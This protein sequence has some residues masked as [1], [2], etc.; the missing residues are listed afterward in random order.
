[1][2]KPT[3]GLLRLNKPL[4]LTDTASGGH[5]K[6]GNFEVCGLRVIKQEDGSMLHTVYK[7]VSAHCYCFS[8]VIN[9]GVT[10]IPS[11]NKESQEILEDKL[12]GKY[13]IIC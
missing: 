5:L 9:N 3:Y 4:T 2:N 12:Y 8:K 1:V 6:M 11:L 7:I 10:T 13:K